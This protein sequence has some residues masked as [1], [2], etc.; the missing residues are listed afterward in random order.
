LVS[1]KSLFVSEFTFST[2]V[3]K[4]VFSQ[5]KKGMNFRRG[6][7]QRILKKLWWFLSATVS[8]AMAETETIDLRP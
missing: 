4:I 5:K 3:A 7:H 1:A 8:N 2:F 6:R